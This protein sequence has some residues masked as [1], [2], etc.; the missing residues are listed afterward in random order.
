MEKI[1]TANILKGEIWMATLCDPQNTIWFFKP[2]ILSVDPTYHPFD[3]KY[4]G[5][6]QVF[7]SE[8]TSIQVHL[9][10][11]ASQSHMDP[12]SGNRR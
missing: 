5:Y 9:L 1:S 12:T 2:A 6:P 11:S 4:V 7:T 3:I 10:P 8:R